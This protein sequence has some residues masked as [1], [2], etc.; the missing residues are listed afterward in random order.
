MTTTSNPWTTNTGQTIGGIADALAFATELRLPCAEKSLPSITSYLHVNESIKMLDLFDKTSKI[1]RELHF[2]ESQLS[3]AEDESDSMDVM[4]ANVMRQ[5]A[6]ELHCFSDYLTVLLSNRHKI[7]AQLSRSQSQIH[8]NSGMD[9]IQMPPKLQPLFQQLLFCMVSQIA[10][11]DQVKDV[12]AW[13]S[14]MKLSHTSF[15]NALQE[16]ESIVC[17]YDE[18]ARTISDFKTALS[19]HQIGNTSRLTNQWQLVQGNYQQPPHQQEHH[20]QQHKHQRQQRI[21]HATKSFVQPSDSRM[22]DITA[23]RFHQYDASRLNSV[24][25]SKAEIEDDIAELVNQ[26]AQISHSAVTERNRKLRNKESEIDV[27]AVARQTNQESIDKIKMQLER[28][29][30]QQRDLKLQLKKSLK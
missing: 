2:H 1:Q 28:L 12:L 20:Y 8:Q 7:S 16:L 18:H 29:R 24:N 26:V 19:K 25:K 23:M 6:H 15:V 9:I 4:D 22:S 3:C 10:N 11:F 13:C 30:L 27:E 5:Q 21:G 17:K 14:D